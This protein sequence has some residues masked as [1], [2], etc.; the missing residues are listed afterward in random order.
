MVFT[1][2]HVGLDS[3]PDGGGKFDL[4][5]CRLPVLKKNLAE[6]QLGLADVGWNS[7][8]WDNHDQPR[9]VSRFG[10]DS[11]EHRANSAKTL[12]HGAAHA[13]GHAVRLSGRRARHDQHLLHQHR[14]VPR[15]RVDQLPR[16][17]R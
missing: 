7:L 13:Q 1:F 4:R 11:P 10:D 6:W 9:A 14:A 12:G 5:R 17:R 8:Y 15:H 3:R 16:G 2:E